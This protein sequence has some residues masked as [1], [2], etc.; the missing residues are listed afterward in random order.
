MSKDFIKQDREKTLS[1]K[2]NLQWHIVIAKILV[3]ATSCKDIV[4]LMIERFYETR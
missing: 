4:S 3:I 2:L 1:L